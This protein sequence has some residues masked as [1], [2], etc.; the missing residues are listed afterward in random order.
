MDTLER[1]L[2]PCFEQQLAAA[3]TLEQLRNAFRS[4]LPENLRIEVALRIIA[5]ASHPADCTWLT[6]HFPTGPVPQALENARRAR[7]PR[8]LKEATTRRDYGR[9]IASTGSNSPIAVKAK[10]EYTRLLLE[11]LG[12]ITTLEQCRDVLGS[13]PYADTFQTFR[14]VVEDKEKELFTRL[15]QETTTI[16]ECLRIWS[17]VSRSAVHHDLVRARIQ[18][19][20]DTESTT[21]ASCLQ[22]VRHCKRVHPSYLSL[23]QRLLELAVTPEEYWEVVH[24]LQAPKGAIQQSVDVQ[25][26]RTTLRAQALNGVLNSTKN[27]SDIHKLFSFNQQGMDVLEKAFTLASSREEF[28]ELLSRATEECLQRSIQDKIAELD[29]NDL[30]AA[31]SVYDC[32]VIYHRSLSPR[33]RYTAYRKIERRLEVMLEHAT[34]TGELQ[35]ILAMCPPHSSI[36]L[37]CLAKLEK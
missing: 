6:S 25:Q 30:E 18:E 1:A 15:L 17:S 7:L 21:F 3:E 22:A 24:S 26:Q 23:V 28:M 33:V 32:W 12:S 5:Q 34:T 14:E 11:E 16:E 2:P 20:A 8:D 37:A 35:S 27:F 13:I 9:I 29:L 31:S 4:G 10:E 36:R 19:L